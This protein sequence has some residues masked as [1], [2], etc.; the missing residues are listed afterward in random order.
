MWCG[1]DDLNLFARILIIII[2]IVCSVY[3]SNK[4]S[5][6]KISIYYVSRKFAIGYNSM[7]PCLKPIL[8][9]GYKSESWNID[10]S[11]DF[12]LRISLETSTTCRK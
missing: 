4:N 11:I 9:L 8:I 5:K 12:S 7:C 3:A 1:I 10:E 6:N 2:I